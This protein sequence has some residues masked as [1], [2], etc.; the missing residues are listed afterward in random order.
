VNS[1]KSFFIGF[2]SATVIA[3]TGAIWLAVRFENQPFR[4]PPKIFVDSGEVPSGKSYVHFEG[5]IGGG[6][7]IANP[8]NVF[9]GTCHQERKTCETSD[10]AMLG[11]DHLGSI[12][13]DTYEIT[14]WSRE[15][16]V[17]ENIFPRCVSIK[18]II[19]RS[20]ET[21]QYVRLPKNPLSNSALCKHIERRSIT[22]TIGDP[23]SRT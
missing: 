14:Q 23:R 9:V 17:A 10:V 2:A 8:N 11:P 3:M 16:I 19:H 4:L 7:S 6:E 13:S 12:S 15:L 1:W 20:K 21:V 5:T 22:W 18:L